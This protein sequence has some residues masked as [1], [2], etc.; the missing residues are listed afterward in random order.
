MH[1]ADFRLILASPTP[2]SSISYFAEQAQH[3]FPT[4]LSTPY[5]RQICTAF[6]ASGRPCWGISQKMKPFCKEPDCPNR[7][8]QGRY[9][10]TTTRHQNHIQAKRATT[11]KFMQVHAR[12]CKNTQSHAMECEIMYEHARTCTSTHEHART[13]T[14]IYIRKC[15]H[16]R[17]HTNTH[18]HTYTNTYT[19]TI[20]MKKRI[21][22]KTTRITTIAKTGYQQREQ[23]LSA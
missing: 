8:E 4:D 11:C 13:H 15:T 6:W 19:H 23:I 21:R 20:P 7:V 10:T 12:A 9:A 18:R 2:I 1:N 5:F 22:T 17:T 3:R 14:N 16:K